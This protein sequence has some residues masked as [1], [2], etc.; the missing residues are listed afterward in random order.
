MPDKSPI[1]YGKAIMVPAVDWQED[2][3]GDRRPV[4]GWAIPGGGFT[5]SENRAKELAKRLHELI[6]QGEKV[7]QKRVA[8]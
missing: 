7:Y 1:K 2:W 5:A 6:A 8:A 4:H 3:K